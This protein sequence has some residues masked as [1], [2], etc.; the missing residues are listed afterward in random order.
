MFGYFGKSAMVAPPP[1]TATV[2]RTELVVQE[3]VVAPEASNAAPEPSEIDI[4]LQNLRIA[5]AA[6]RQAKEAKI[7]SVQET[8]Q[9][10]AA[11]GRDTT[12]LR[13]EKAGYATEAE[14]LMGGQ[15]GYSKPASALAGLGVLTQDVVNM[16]SEITRLTSVV[17]Q[18]TKDVAA[19]VVPRSE[20]LKAIDELQAR[21]SE[22]KKLTSELSGWTDSPTS[23]IL[24]AGTLVTGAFLIY[25]TCF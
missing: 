16:T 23:K 17:K 14:K 8:Q 10:Q 11:Y 22:A 20:L 21:S 24:I 6:K 1:P 15:T 12:Q 7:R 3:P 5:V 25:K 19:G 2:V 13:P 18:L 4:Q 9:K